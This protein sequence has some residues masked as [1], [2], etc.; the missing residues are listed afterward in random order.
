MQ[1]WSNTL[2]LGSLRTLSSVSLLIFTHPP[3]CTQQGAREEQE[4]GGGCL[5]YLRETSSTTNAEYCGHWK[6]LLALL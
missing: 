2:A 5:Q 4:A 3:S 6:G 1:C